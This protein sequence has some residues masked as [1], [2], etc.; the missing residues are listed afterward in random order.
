MRLD[1]APG[2]AGAAA[3]EIDADPER[4]HGEDEQDIIPSLAAIEFVAEDF[5]RIDGDAGGEAAL[6]LVFA[7]EVNHDEMQRE[8]RDRKI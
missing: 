2:A 1:R 3:Q 4:Q 8:R 7:A 6:G 5:R